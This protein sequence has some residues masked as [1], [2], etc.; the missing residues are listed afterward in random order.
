MTPR[1]SSQTVT[2]TPWHICE[3][4]GDTMP[5]AEL[6]G[7]KGQPRAKRTLAASQSS[8]PSAPAPT[9]R[10]SSPSLGPSLKEVPEAGPPP[11][12][13]H[14]GCQT[15]NG[16]GR[17]WQEPVRPDHC[18]MHSSPP[19]RKC[20]EGS[21]PAGP[22]R[23]TTFMAHREVPRDRV[24]VPTQLVCPLETHPPS[25]AQPARTFPDRF[26]LSASASPLVAF[27]PPES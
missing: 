25:P 22:P 10:C 23:G 24:G 27:S 4:L 9:P 14:P 2:A 11:L 20:R 17:G 19:A 5:Q 8:S 3:F 16:W 18:R 13:S 26:Y 12:S 7:G 6:A 21:L 1:V 15:A